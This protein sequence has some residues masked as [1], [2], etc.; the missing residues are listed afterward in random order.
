MQRNV[1]QPHGTC[2]RMQRVT[3]NPLARKIGGIPETQDSVNLRT[4]D[5][6]S[7][8]LAGN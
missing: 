6:K 1:P 3:E 4:K 2:P 8:P 5:E 7:L